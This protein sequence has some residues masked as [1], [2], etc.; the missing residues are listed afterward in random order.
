[1][2]RVAGG[3]LAKMIGGKSLIFMGDSAIPPE[4]CETPSVRG[5]QTCGDLT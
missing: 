2:S 5:D 1:M 3:D 4:S